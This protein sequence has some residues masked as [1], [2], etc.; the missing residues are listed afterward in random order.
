MEKKKKSSAC[1]SAVSVSTTALSHSLS[2]CIISPVGRSIK[3]C[4]PSAS[5]IKEEEE[6]TPAV[7][8]YRL[9]TFT[10]L[11]SSS[12]SSCKTAGGHSLDDGFS[13]RGK[14]KGRKEKKKGRRRESVRLVMENGSIRAKSDN[15]TQ[16]LGSIPV[17]VEVGLGSCHRSAHISILNESENRHMTDGIWLS[18]RRARAEISRAFPPF[19]FNTADTAEN[20]N[21]LPFQGV[22][23]L[24]SL[25]FF[26]FVSSRPDVFLTC[27]LLLLLGDIKRGYAELCLYF[28]I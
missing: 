24:P 18:I 20:G 11:R 22:G 21:Q 6:E 8:S 19:G 13:F 25:F 26:V 23:R 12:S 3:S 28:S 9:P 10:L 1:S 5:K 17:V 27:P 14:K 7:K 15:N 2:S 16:F 4:R